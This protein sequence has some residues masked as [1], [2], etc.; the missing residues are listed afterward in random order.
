MWDSAL[1][2][3]LQAQSRHADINKQIGTEK[4]ATD[5]GGY[6]RQSE[7]I[8]NYQASAKSIDTYT[9]LARSVGDRLNV[10][11]LALE[12][13]GEALLSAE[14]LHVLADD[15]GNGPFLVHGHPS[16]GTAQRARHGGT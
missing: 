6:G 5:I 4:I 13:S 9:Q 7:V 11:N 15:F 1:F 3:L 16:V 8:A 10:Q 2:N 14:A 12:Q